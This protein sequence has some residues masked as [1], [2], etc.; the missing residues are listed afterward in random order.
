MEHTDGRIDILGNLLAKRVLQA[1]EHPLSHAVQVEDAVARGAGIDL[2]MV[3]DLFE[4]DVTGVGLIEQLVLQ[5][6]LQVCNRARVP[7]TLEGSPWG[8]RT[9]RNVNGL[10][11]GSSSA[12]TI[13]TLVLVILRL[14]SG[15]ALRLFL[16]ALLSSSGRTALTVL[17]A[18]VVVSSV[19]VSPM[20]RSLRVVA[21]IVPLLGSLAA[22][23]LWRS[24][25]SRL[26]R[27]TFPRRTHLSRRFHGLWNKRLS[28]FTQLRFFRLR[29]RRAVSLAGLTLLIHSHRSLSVIPP[30][31]ITSLILP[32]FILSRLRIRI[33]CRIYS[34]RIRVSISK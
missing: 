32:W 15:I 22:L 6:L 1:S 25:A 13:P 31:S 21:P 33:W 4:A 24:L 27:L 10:L 20:R 29:A 19:V 17:R 2:L 18:V 30:V 5:S 11:V 28:S 16:T 8:R 7:S 3:L 34:C 14:W 23:V 12:E 26:T 9:Y